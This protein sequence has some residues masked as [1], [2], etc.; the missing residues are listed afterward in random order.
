VAEQLQ[1]SHPR[2]DTTEFRDCDQPILTAT[3]IHYDSATRI[4]G[5]PREIGVELPSLKGA[6]RWRQLHSPLCD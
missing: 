2:L 6:P 4:R 1:V 5:I 3:S